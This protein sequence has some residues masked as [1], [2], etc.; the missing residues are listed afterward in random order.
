MPSYVGR[1]LKSGVGLRSAIAVFIVAL[2]T[3][4]ATMTVQRG[5]SA[6]IDYERQVRPLIV[7]NCLDCHSGDKRKGGLSLATYADILEGG[8]DGPIVR[9]G[10]GAGS[11]IVHRLQGIDGEQMPKDGAALSDA[12][13]AV[14]QRWIDE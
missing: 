3:A 2:W 8:K 6:T 5:G 12:E 10:N 13:I 9:P 4:V 11:L 1:T 7:E 14:I